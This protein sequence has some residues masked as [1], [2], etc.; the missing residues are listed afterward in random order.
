MKEV[1]G[2]AKVNTP[3]EVLSAA[4][5]NFEKPDELVGRRLDGRFLIERNLTEGGADQGGIGV[6]Y[7]ASDQKLM[8]K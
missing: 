1:K 2:S 5:I 4:T 3:D 8:G 7:L 6:V